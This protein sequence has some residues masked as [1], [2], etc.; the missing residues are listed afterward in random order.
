MQCIIK[1]T[2][3]ACGGCWASTTSA[4]WRMEDLCVFHHTSTRGCTWYTLSSKT[5]VRIYTHKHNCIYSIHTHTECLITDYA[6]LSGARN[7]TPTLIEMKFKSRNALFSCSRSVKDEL[8]TQNILT[9]LLTYLLEF[10]ITLTRKSIQRDPNT[11]RTN[12]CTGINTYRRAW[13]RQCAY[14]AHT[15]VNVIK[16][17][18]PAH[19]VQPSPGWS[20]RCRWIGWLGCMPAS[21]CIAGCQSLPLPME[22]TWFDDSCDCL[23]LYPSCICG[24]RCSTPSGN[25]TSMCRRTLCISAGLRTGMLVFFFNVIFFQVFV[26]TYI[27]STWQYCILCILPVDWFIYLFISWLIHLLLHV[28]LFIDLCVYIYFS[29]SLSLFLFLINCFNLF[30]WFLWW[31]INDQANNK[32]TFWLDM[33]TNGFG[34]SQ[35]RSRHFGLSLRWTQMELITPMFA[36]NLLNDLG[37]H[38]FNM[39]LGRHHL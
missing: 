28:C 34:H 21:W 16:S 5:P 25:L 12:T 32:F 9:Y 10:V 29:F 2:R 15:C 8:Y 19:E 11:P 6:V 39:H 4:V 20:W 13:V 7:S 23:F 37:P 31:L 33:C 22:G 35:S 3:H 38:V 18:L 30:C 26:D 27:D 17:P 24:H 14:S 36:T 1:R